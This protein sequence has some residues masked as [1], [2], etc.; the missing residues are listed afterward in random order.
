[1]GRPDC[2]SRV[3][4]ALAVFPWF[5]MAP[6]WIGAFTHIMFGAIIGRSYVWLRKPRMAGIP[7]ESRYDDEATR[8]RCSS[9]GAPRRP[10]WTMAMIAGTGPAP[11]KPER[12]GAVSVRLTGSAPMEDS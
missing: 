8:A 4:G 6:D 3:H 5:V 10:M 1:M 7:E 12:F 9:H 2:R 11:H